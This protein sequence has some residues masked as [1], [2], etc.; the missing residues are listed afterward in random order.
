MVGATGDHELLDAATTATQHRPR[1][2]SVFMHRVRRSTVGL[3]KKGLR[4]V[5]KEKGASQFGRV[6]AV[7][8]GMR[9]STNIAIIKFIKKKAVT[10]STDDAARALAEAL[11][12]NT[13]L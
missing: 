12:V 5:T 9:A 11:R 3:L 13:T 7:V 2:S 10:V 4:R 8:K 1:L 6:L